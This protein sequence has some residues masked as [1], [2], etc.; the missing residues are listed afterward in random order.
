MNRIR[1]LF[2]CCLASAM[3]LSGCDQTQNGKGTTPVYRGLSVSQS[4]LSYNNSTYNRNT[5]SYKSRIKHDDEIENDIESLANISVPSNET[6]TYYI[7]PEKTF[8]VEVHLSNPNDFEIQSFT[9][10]GKKYANYMFKEGSTMELILL[11]ITAPSLSGY[12]DYT[13]D[14][15]K[16][17]DGSRIK[18]VDMSYGNKSV[19]IGIPYSIQPNVTINSFNVD[20]TYFEIN[21]SIFDSEN[22]LKNNDI[23]IYLSDGK[24]IIERKKISIGENTVKFS[25]LSMSTAYQYGIVAIYDFVDGNGLS[26]IWFAKNV[27]ATLSAFSFEN[28]SI[29]KDS[30]SFDVKKNGALG[31]ISSISL[32][33]STTGEIVQEGDSEIRSF[34]SLLTNHD[35]DIYIDYSY[36]VGNNKIENWF[37]T[38]VKTNAVSIPTIEYKTIGRGKESITY[39]VFVHDEDSVVSINS[40]SLYKN[41]E[42]LIDQGTKLSGEFSGLL[43]NNLYELRVYYS[44]DLRDGNGIIQEFANKEIVTDNKV[45]PTIVV[46]NEDVTDSSIKAN[47]VFSDVDNVGLLEK[48]ELFEGENLISTNSSKQID[49]VDLNY[50][51][52]YKLKVTFSYDLNDGRGVQTDFFEKSFKTSPYLSVKSCVLLSNELVSDGE[53]IYL[54]ISIENPLNVLCKSVKINGVS[55]PCS[56][57]STQSMIY[58]E[59]L[60]EGQFESGLTTLQIEQIIVEI[61]SSSF[62]IKP[63]ENNTVSV[64][65]LGNLYV[66]SASCSVNGVDVDRCYCCSNVDLHVVFENASDYTINSVEVEYKNGTTGTFGPLRRVDANNWYFDNFHEGRESYCGTLTFEIKRI[67]YSYQ[68]F[69]SSLPVGIGKTSIFLIRNSEPILIS[70]ASQL[71]NMINDEDYC[72]YQL[73]NDIDFSGIEWEPYN[74]YGLLNGNNHS[75]KN[76]RFIKTILDSKIN[77]ALF[78]RIYGIVE[79]LKFESCS[80]FATIQSSTDAGYESNFAFLTYDNQGLISNCSFKN[81][82]LSINNEKGRGKASIIALAN[83]ANIRDCSIVDSSLNLNVKESYLG[84]VCEENRGS[85]VGCNVELSANSVSDCSSGTISFQV[86]GFGA[87]ANRNAGDVY[88]NFVKCSLTGSANDA[89]SLGGI[90][91]GNE[92]YVKYNVVEASIT[93]EARSKSLGAICGATWNKG[94]I[95]LNYSKVSKKTMRLIGRTYNGS[96]AGVNYSVDDM[97]YNDYINNVFS[98]SEGKY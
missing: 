91:A 36:F 9:L 20:T 30:I 17:I 5:T 62:A 94:Y 82:S 34:G 89:Y 3:F 15:I 31:E 32:C 93:L 75:I 33:D 67:N 90:V 84:G 41:G 35:Y 58:V 18:D 27:F 63:N 21:F 28:I 22:V 25:N 39:T 77:F 59:I 1:K 86:P 66:I 16:Y 98:L 51:S 2:C 80:I 29:Q 46:S 71:A 44:Y 37:A 68:S 53:T 85:I 54:G 42:L 40:V 7:E 13:I 88:R 81:T 47:L 12:Y 69:S 49:F 48:V 23:Y 8:I 52:D 56:G 83:R 74:F 92:G 26:P 73:T 50:Y 43:S 19:K 24:T 11:E 97:N 87:I 76:F 55:Y 60:N 45:K 78:N 79:N 38:N 95:E 64:M 70:S 96:D 61:N 4:N 6:S 10:N 65:I 72:Y 14:A 57:A